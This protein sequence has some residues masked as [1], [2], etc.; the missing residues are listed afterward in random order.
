MGKGQQADCCDGTQRENLG[1][2]M[3]DMFGLYVGLW[4]NSQM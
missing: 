2:P 3:R 4:R 1:E